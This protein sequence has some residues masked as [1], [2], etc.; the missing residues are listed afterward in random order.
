MT[1]RGAPGDAMARRYADLLRAGDGGVYVALRVSDVAVVRQAADSLRLA[2]HRSSS[3]P[4]QFLGFPS[5]SPAAA[6]F[7]TSGAAPVADADSIVAHEPSVSALAEVWLE[8]GA[9][10]GALLRRLGAVACDA[11]TS[12][13]GRVGRRWALSRGQLVIVPPRG[14]RRPGVLGVV[15]TTTAQR[16]TI[17]E[18]MRTF[19][20]RYQPPSPPR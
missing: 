19:W 9:E 8:G 11:A 4:W 10:L 7:F 12:P 1:V 6:V 13:D 18:P 17:L 15:L 14:G 20:I 16:D 3:G 5:T 2:A